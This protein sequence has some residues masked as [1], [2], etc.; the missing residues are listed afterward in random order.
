MIESY[1]RTIVLLGALSLFS[2]LLAA[3]SAP[4]SCDG[5]IATVRV[6]TIKPTGSVDGFLAAVA[7]HK[8]WTISHGVT[9]DEIFATRVILRDEK[10]REQS[11][12]TTELMTFH[13]H[14]SRQP[15]PKHDEAYDAF[16]KLYRDNSDIK[17][18]YDIC[19]PNGP[20]R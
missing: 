20:Q 14:G 12:S 13:I 4:L 5:R 10:T 15:G 16:V 7:A 1:M 9:N 19:M 18:A 6:S 17:L 2:A 11:Y 3:Q 8:A